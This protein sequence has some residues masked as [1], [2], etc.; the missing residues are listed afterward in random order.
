MIK[1]HKLFTLVLLLSLVP[2]FSAVAADKTSLTIYSSVSPGSVSPNMYR[3]LSNTDNGSW[4]YGNQVPG[5]A[6]IR[7]Q[8]EIDLNV[9]TNT[10]KFAD[11]A[12]FIDPTTVSFI[13]LTDPSGTSVL[14]QDYHFDLVSNQKL[15][16][17]YLGQDITVDQELGTGVQSVSG[18]LLSAAGG[19]ILQDQTGK[20]T[21]IKNYS[22]IHFPEL[23]GGLIT[24]PTLIWTVDTDKSGK[25]TVETSYQTEGLTWWADY[26]ALYSENK[27][28]NGGYLDL[29]AWVSIVNK[30]GASF[31]DAK[32]KLIAGDVHHVEPPQARLAVDAAKAFISDETKAGFAEKAFFEFHLYTLGRATTIPDNSTK[33]IELFPTVTRVP[34]E[35]QFVYYGAALPYYGSLM[36]NRDLGIESNKKVDVYLKFKNNKAAGLG[37]P[38]PAGRLR[39]SKQDEADGSIEFIGEDIIDH[40]PKDE[41]VL[42][43]M[44]EAFDIVGER[45]QVDFH[46]DDARHTMEET[47]E[48][49]LSNHKDNDEVVIVKENMFRGPDWEI[50]NPSNKY[51]KIDA[52]TIYFPVSVKKDDT[53][54]LQYTVRYTW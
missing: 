27:E 3:P 31:D 15:L 2:H 4:L 20:V 28:G 19:L 23:P 1:A 5:Y 13:S 35:K 22:G 51:D 34:V 6:V 36:K 8:R 37:I 39:V 42:I 49:T 24:K 43:K 32:L 16:E 17:R 45:R 47:I 25:Q 50:I 30:S 40:T 26:N 38:L 12:A 7:E 48:I 52:H 10:V 53:S 18:K 21:S 29:G 46:V 33:Q 11:V 44:G 9:G 41:D 54:K 14:E